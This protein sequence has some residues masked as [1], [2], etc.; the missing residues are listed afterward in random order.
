MECLRRRGGVE[1]RRRRRSFLRESTELEESLD[2]SSD[3]SE[4]SESESDES[5]SEDSA[6]SMA[7]RCSIMSLGAFFK[8][9]LISSVMT[10][11]PI[12][13]K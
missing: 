6:S 8:Y 7:R 13:V 1:L 11:R 4:E 2:E 12:L 3:E 10:P 9:S 5:E